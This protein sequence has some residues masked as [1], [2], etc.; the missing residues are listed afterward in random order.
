MTKTI[1]KYGLIAG[2]IV[3]LPFIIT[4]N[5]MTNSDGQV[6]FTLGMLLGYAA[7]L[8]AFSLVFVAIRNYRNE[9]DGLV[10]FG[11]AF[12]IGSLIVL[13]ASTIYVI[14]WLIDYYYFIP[15][16]AE[17]Y[18]EHTLNELKANGAGPEELASKSKEMAEFSEMYKNPFYNA[19]IT[20]VEILPVG[21]VITAISALILKR[22]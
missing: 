12:Q 14:T 19:M 20:Y 16:F 11:K 2:A 10:S 22:K 1:I 17:K 9:H 3:A 4:T 21:L 13:I 6:N 18:A 7:M 5:I 15:D 8:L